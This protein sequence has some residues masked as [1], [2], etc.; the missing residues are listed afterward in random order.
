[1]TRRLAPRGLLHSVELGTGQAPHH[2]GTFK[3]PPTTVH[4]LPDN[5]ELEFVPPRLIVLKM[6]GDFEGDAIHTLFDVIEQHI[7]GESFWLFEVDISEL[8]HA[9]PSARR[10]GAERISK[11]PEYSM[12]LYG[13]G[14]A[15]RAVSTIFLK[16]TELFSG[17]RDISNTFVKTQSQARTWLLEE[18]CRRASGSAR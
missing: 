7:E 10:A 13:G 18:G 15:Q 6:K 14:L 12:A 11:T 9:H 3:L 4:D 1:M 5:F 8:G 2:R 16:V 17:D